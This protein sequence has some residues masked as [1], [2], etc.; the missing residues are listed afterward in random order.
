MKKWLHFHRDDATWR[1]VVN[2]KKKSFREM[3]NTIKH[4]QGQYTKL[5]HFQ[6]AKQKIKKVIPIPIASKWIK[7]LE[8]NPMKEV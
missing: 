3:G 5:N 4:I 1:R 8:I 7:Y 6:W 2:E